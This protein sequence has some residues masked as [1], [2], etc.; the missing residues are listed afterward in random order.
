[1]IFVHFIFSL[2]AAYVIYAMAD[3][4]YSAILTIID[5]MNWR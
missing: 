2:F 4:V 5:I 3:T 1:M